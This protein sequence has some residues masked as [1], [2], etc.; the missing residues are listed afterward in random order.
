MA[1]DIRVGPLQVRTDTPQITDTFTSVV[2]GDIVR[3]IQS[4]DAY[5][6]K[7]VQ[8]SKKIAGINPRLAY[9]VVSGAEFIPAHPSR[10]EVR[11]PGRELRYTNFILHRPAG[12]DLR[13]FARGIT[14]QDGVN[15]TLKQLVD[16]YTTYCSTDNLMGIFRAKGDQVSTHFIIG[17]DGRLIQMIDLADKAWHTKTKPHPKLSGETVYNANSVGV[18]L[19]GAVQPYAKEY[20]G[21]TESERKLVASPF[22]AAQLKTLAWLLR[23]FHDNSDYGL[24]LD[25][26]HVLL[27]RD[28]DPA[29]RRDPAET[30][31]LASLLDIALS[32]APVTTGYQEGVSIDEAEKRAAVALAGK[33]TTTTQQLTAFTEVLTSIVQGMARAA[34]ISAADRQ[35]YYAAATANMD[36]LVAARLKQMSMAVQTEKIIKS[37]KLPVQANR[38]GLSFD[39]DTNTWLGEEQ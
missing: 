10:F 20:A 6:N 29:D 37:A 34:G 39:Y 25:D 28:I 33:L 13:A 26:K 24:A 16:F 22:P 31:D 11:G 38:K 15:Y 5:A 35:K 23:W 2:G 4:A 19:E 7:R 18:E 1:N 9:R 3:S 21:L 12:I 27:H 17:L 30:F 32:M 36:T 14:G 8:V